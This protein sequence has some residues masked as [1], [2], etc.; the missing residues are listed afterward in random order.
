M[1]PVGEGIEFEVGGVTD[2][3]EKSV[4]SFGV[5]VTVVATPSTTGV[6]APVSVWVASKHS[7]MSELTK[8][9]R[10]SVPGPKLSIHPE[11]EAT[12]VR[13]TTVRVTIQFL[14]GVAEE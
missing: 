4:I 13:N 12:I 10:I 6:G 2:V 8:L 1:V 3:V 11:A 14:S 5:L 7:P 9:H